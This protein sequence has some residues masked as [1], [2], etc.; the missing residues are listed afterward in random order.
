L[1]THRKR[2]IA[3]WFKADQDSNNGKKQVLYEEGGTTRGLNTYINDDGLL[4]VGGWNQGGAKSNRTSSW[5]ESKQK[6]SDGK[7]H[8]VTLVLDGTN[9]AKPN[10]LTAYLDGKKIGSDRGSQLLQHSDRIALGNIAGRTRF[11]DGI[12]T[13]KQGLI[14]SLDEA[15]IFNQALT[16][17][18]VQALTQQF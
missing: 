13:G 10:A 9:K 12:G 5:I 15:H 2:S 8:H 3:L 6:V 1:G 16:G 7:W 17:Q 14:G 18:E 11:H 4:Y